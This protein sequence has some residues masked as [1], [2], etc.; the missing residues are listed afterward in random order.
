MP[1][2]K[3]LSGKDI[4]K[5]LESFG[6]LVVSQKGSHIKLQR[7]NDSKKQILVIPNH[8]ELDKGTIR[9]IFN[10]VSKYISEQE[11]K[12]YFYS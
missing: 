9:A 10:Q 6:F 5:I 8:P 1:K 7:I 12:S 2:L 4:L 3:V 11:L